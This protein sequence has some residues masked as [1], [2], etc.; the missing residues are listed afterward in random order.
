MFGQTINSLNSPISWIR[1]IHDPK[2][3]NANLKGDQNKESH[4]IFY[5]HRVNENSS[6]VHKDKVERIE[7]SFSKKCKH[8]PIF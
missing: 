4:L 8:W 7:N 3:Q 6:K 5:H 2:D 1:L